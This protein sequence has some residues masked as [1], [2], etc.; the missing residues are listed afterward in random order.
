MFN[1]E[2]FRICFSIFFSVLWNAWIYLWKSR[3]PLDFLQRR[4]EL[5]WGWLFF[6]VGGFLFLFFFLNKMRYTTK[7]NCFPWSDLNAQSLLS[8]DACS[9]SCPLFKLWVRDLGLCVL[10][11]VCQTAA[12]WNAPEFQC[13]T[14]NQGSTSG[15]KHE[16]ITP[17]FEENSLHYGEL[18]TTCD[19]FI[20]TFSK[21]TIQM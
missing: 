11:P 9:V 15:T 19:L 6:L 14:A 21:Q 18:F 4:V 3:V 20:Y 5:F 8:S 17:N 13:L 10:V 7:K 16:Q 2:A 12:L 1:K